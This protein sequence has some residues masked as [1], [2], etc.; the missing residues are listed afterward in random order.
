MLTKRAQRVLAGIGIGVFA[1]A[2]LI[3][4][5]LKFES[6]ADNPS[7]GSLYDALWWTV[8]TLTTVGYGDT[9]P[10]T[11]F[12]RMIGFIFVFGSFS[13]FGF[14]IGRITNMLS[15]ISEHKKLGYEGTKFRNHAVIIGWSSGGHSVVEQLI[16]VNKPCAVITDNRNDID[17]INETYDKKHVFT[18]FADY[19]NFDIFKKANIE[20]AAIVYVNLDDD[21]AKLVHILTLKKHFKNLRFVV[22]LDNANLKSTFHS[23]GVTHAV[24]KNEISSKLLASYIFEPDVAQY[25]E[26][27]LSF[28]ENDIDYDIKEYRVVP[29]NPLAG[30]T[31]NDVFYEIKREYNAVLIGISKITEHGRE[32]LKN[33]KED[34]T[35]NIGDYLI[36]IMNG[37]STRRMKGIFQ[38]EEGGY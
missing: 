32:L 19:N 37:E 13:I 28:A 35:I 38:V 24:S 18:L 20:S 34:V 33:P 36:L 1:Y 15:D 17:L 22:T 23:A 8:V 3:Y 21:T 16:G 6:E 14:L 30:R 2:I 5:L 7:I 10:V 4:F 29:E 9:Y 27:I 25:S 11:T 31:Y 12:G 26:D